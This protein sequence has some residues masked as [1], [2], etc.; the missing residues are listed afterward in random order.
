MWLA[1]VFFLM[2]LIACGQAILHS[3]ISVGGVALVGYAFCYFGTAAFAGSYKARRIK[4][5]G[6]TD[7]ASIG[8]IALVVVAAGLGFTVWS[9]F[10][11]GLFGF[12]IPGVYWAIIGIVIAALT[13]SKE[14][15]L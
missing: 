1:F 8:A 9:D 2:T 4:G 14:H 6:W 12:V 11:V 7:L 3:S 15:A 13:T 5:T 10:R